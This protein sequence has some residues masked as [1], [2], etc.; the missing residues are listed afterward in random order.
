MPDFVRKALLP[1]RTSLPS[2]RRHHQLA[3]CVEALLQ[4]REGAGYHRAFDD[5]CGDRMLRG[6]LDAGDDCQRYG[7]L[8]AFGV[9]VRQCGSAESEGAVLWA[10]SESISSMRSIASALRDRISDSAPRSIA[11]IIEI[12]A[13]RP[14]AHEQAMIKTATA[15]TRA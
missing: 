8:D 10:M 12:D 1:T 9:E 4:F 11:N 7:L 15:F 5:R 6:L 3:R 2:T 14:T 13:A